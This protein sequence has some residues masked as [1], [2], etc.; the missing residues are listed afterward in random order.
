MILDLANLKQLGVKGQES[1]VKSQESR[2]KS[3]GSRVKSQE[4]RVNIWTLD[5]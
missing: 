4:S 2:V 5:Y 1:R 3:Q